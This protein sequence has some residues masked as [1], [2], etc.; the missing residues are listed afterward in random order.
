MVQF[1][2]LSR[3]PTSEE[4]PCCDDTPVDNEL[5]N[6]VPNLLLNILAFIWQER[7]A[8]FFGVDMG[9]YYLWENQRQ[10]VLVPDGFLSVGVTR[11]KGERGRLSYV[12]WEENQVP[13]LLAIEVVSKKYNDEYEQKKEKYRNLGVVYYLIYNPN[14]WQRDK[15]QPL[16][17]YRLEEGEYILQ[18]NNEPYWLPEIGLG[19]GRSRG[20][21]TVWTREWLYW[22]DEQ[23][24]PYPLPEESE[25]QRAESERQRAESER[26]RADRAEKERQQAITRLLSLGL[27]IEQIARVYDLSPTEVKTII[28]RLDIDN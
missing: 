22:Y 16:E 14:H 19:I 9:I 20:T 28:E 1:E 24:N 3:L 18:A 10:P 21:Y 27:T 13:P 15:H 7:Q 5:Q 26:Q 8:W 23:G 11:R 2:P 4:L 12:L 6:L 25:R 17:L